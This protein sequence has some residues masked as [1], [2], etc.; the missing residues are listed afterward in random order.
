MERAAGLARTMPVAALG[1]SRS[2]ITTDPPDHDAL[3]KVINRG[4]TPRRIDSWEPRVRQ[5]VAECWESVGD[6]ADFD[7]IRDIAV[8]VPVV[9][10]AEMLGIEPERQDDFKRWSDGIIAGATGSARSGPESELFYESMGELSH[11][12]LQIAER[13]QADPRDDLV[14]VVVS[15]QGGDAGVSPGDV[16]QFVI[17]LLVAGNETTTNLIGNATNLLLANPEQLGH[18][19]RDPGLIPGLVEETLR[20]EAPIQFLIRN[21]TRD[22]EIAGQP[23][24]RGEVVIPLIGAANR[25]P[26][27][28]EDP[29]RFDVTRG[30]PAHLAFGFGVHFCLGASLA[31]LEAR[32]ALESIVPRL[33]DLR[34]TDPE[35]PIEPI[36]SFMIRGPR[37]LP[38]SRAA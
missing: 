1:Q 32:L 33:G 21:A 27:Q 17:L 29:E 36:D 14:S 23:I 4:F 5:V 11:Y 26:R 22:L 37:S 31:R 24:R 18:V 6:R 35:A 19:Q 38:L 20:C 8:P 13:R 28:F 10:I 34:R 7:L 2:L 9:V 16:V 30:S 3:R 15:A 12:I 25:D